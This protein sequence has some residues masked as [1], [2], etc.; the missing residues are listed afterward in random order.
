MQ[1]GLSLQALDSWA[2]AAEQLIGL[3]KR[4]VMQEAAI[5]QMPVISSRVCSRLVYEREDGHQIDGISVRSG[6][7]NPD[8]TMKDSVGIS[9]RA[10]EHRVQ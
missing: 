8:K 9:E 10:N 7:A 3:F 2:A 1:S 4:I 5:F 6:T